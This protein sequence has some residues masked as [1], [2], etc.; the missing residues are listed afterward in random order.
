MFMAWIILD[1]LVGCLGRLAA[2][3]CVRNLCFD[4]ARPV[5]VPSEH[6][7]DSKRAW[8]IAAVV[9]GVVLIVIS[10]VYFAEPAHG[11]PSFF[12]GYAKHSNHHHVKHG[13]AALL[14]GLACF[15][16]AWFQIGPRKRPAT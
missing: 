7:L 4:G 2:R 3:P 9:V 14:L 15:A 11:L 6:Q 8:A 5:P 12:P 1:P 16:F 10:I 13:I